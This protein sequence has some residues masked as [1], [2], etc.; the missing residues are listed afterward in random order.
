MSILK[1]E[2]IARTIALIVRDWIGIAILMYMFCVGGHLEIGDLYFTTEHL[3]LR[4]L[5]IFS[6]L[7]STKENFKAPGPHVP[8]DD[9]H[10]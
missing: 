9:W 8:N 6:S 2:D 7:R 5:E 4:R 1:V 3:T 10:L